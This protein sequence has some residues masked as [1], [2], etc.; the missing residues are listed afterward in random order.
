MSGATANF[1]FSGFGC[2]L[3]SRLVFKEKNPGNLGPAL[4]RDDAVFDR[5]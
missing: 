2:E 3:G 1:M 4:V 5:I